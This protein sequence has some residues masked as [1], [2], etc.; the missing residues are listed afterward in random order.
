MIGLTRA[1]ESLDTEGVSPS[2]TASDKHK[3]HLTEEDEPPL[4][5]EDALRNAPET[6]DGF[7]LVPPVV[8]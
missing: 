8:E 2:F 3:G 5:N 7:F 4:S 6:Q 1:F